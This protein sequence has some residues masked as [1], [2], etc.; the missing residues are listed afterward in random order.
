MVDLNQ[1]RPTDLWYV[2]G[3][4]ATDG[5]LSIDGRH[6]NITSKDRE[7]LYLIR[8]A[9]LLKNKIGRKRS[10][11][12]RAKIYS[13]LQ[14]GDVKFYRY[15]LQIGL[16]PRKSLTLSPLNIDTR[17]FSD[18]LRGV[19]DGDGNISSWIHKSNYH[20]QWCLRIYSA[21]YE[22]IEWL[23]CKIEKNFDIRPKIYSVKKAYRPNTLYF[24]RF[25]QIE[26]AKILKS[27]YY[28]DSLSL[29]RKSLQ[30]KLCLQH[31]PKMV[32]YALRPR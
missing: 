1:V 20:K 12:Q 16:R 29:K 13:Q 6:I 18:F 8:K 28:N 26:A 11:F 31:S 15:L 5:Y 10:G 14:F 4:I 7:H 23:A 30:A 3:Y 21:S 27:I 25:G 17:Y 22:F 32:D 24:L 9:L 2:I 19:I